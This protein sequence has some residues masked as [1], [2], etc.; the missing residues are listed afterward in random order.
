MRFRPDDYTRDGLWPRATILPRDVRHVAGKA[1]DQ[2]RLIWARDDA[3]GRSSPASPEGAEVSAR[4]YLS[5]AR[6]AGEAAQFRMVVNHTGYIVGTPVGRAKYAVGRL[7]DHCLEDSRQ[8][9]NP[10]IGEPR[11]GIATLITNI[12][13][14]R[15]R[16]AFSETDARNLGQRRHRAFPLRDEDRA[17]PSDDLSYPGRSAR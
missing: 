17:L 4:N 11:R 12:E 15:M 9:V 5:L 10:A 3:L 16:G 6:V 8:F 13:M 1:L 7:V 2:L 14:L